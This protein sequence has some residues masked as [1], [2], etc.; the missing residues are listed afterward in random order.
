MEFQGVLHYELK[1]IISSDTPSDADVPHF[2]QS[3]LK[4]PI[5]MLYD[6]S[7]MEIFTGQILFSTTMHLGVY[8]FRNFGQNTTK[9]ACNQNSL[10]SV[11]E[12]TGSILLTYLKIFSPT[13]LCEG[14]PTDTL[15][16]QPTEI[17]FDMDNYPLEEAWKL[18]LGF[19]VKLPQAIM[20]PDGTFNDDL[21]NIKNVQTCLDGV[22]QY[23]FN[24]FIDA[25]NYIFCRSQ[26]E[27]I[28]LKLEQKYKIPNLYDQLLLVPE[29][30]FS[31]CY[32]NY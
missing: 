29:N 6:K 26:R 22:K 4:F 27:F 5:D 28:Y 23:N 9:Y 32:I 12:E 8:R 19:T 16:I 31:D 20:K 30:G 3:C 17:A 13:F 10:D 25:C 18:Y 24:G 7:Q 15:V 2:V 21:S 11:N 1:N 14:M